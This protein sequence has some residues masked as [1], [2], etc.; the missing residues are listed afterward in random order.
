MN[1]PPYTSP[2]AADPVVQTWDGGW[3]VDA[4]YYR[5]SP[6]T[7]YANAAYKQLLD[8]LDGQCASLPQWFGQ[9]G[10]GS[11]RGRACIVPGYRS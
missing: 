5:M 3:T 11:Q 9:H 6:T 10:W 2:R 8:V 1:A 7:A 4:E